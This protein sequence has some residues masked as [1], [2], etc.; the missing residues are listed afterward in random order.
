MMHA[1]NVP[2]CLLYARLQLVDIARHCTHCRYVIFRRTPIILFVVKMLNAS[3]TGN[4]KDKG[5]KPK[6]KIAEWT[7]KSMLLLNKAN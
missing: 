7:I 5:C 1:F 4:S 3:K 2:Q 6:V